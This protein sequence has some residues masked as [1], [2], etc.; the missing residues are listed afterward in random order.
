MILAAGLGTRMLP[1][2]ATTPKPLVK[3]KQQRLIEY[4]I[5]S[6]KQAGIFDIVI[7]IFHLAETIRATLGDGS[8]YGV[9]LSYSEESELLNTGFGIKHA[10]NCGLLHHQEF[11]VVSSDIVCDLSLTQLPA[12]LTKLAHIILAPNPSFNPQGDFS[13]D[14]SGLLLLATSN[15]N[16]NYTFASI[17]I[18]TAEFF[19]NC[20]DQPFPLSLPI[21]QAIASQQ[22]TGQLYLGAWQNIGTMEQL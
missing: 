14:A 6:L 10:I 4:S 12:N 2:T 7:N 5:N 13:L 20:P 1:L 21:Q 22:I 18:F 8:Q 3:F 11:I 19:N 16:H 9:K 15:P 17:G